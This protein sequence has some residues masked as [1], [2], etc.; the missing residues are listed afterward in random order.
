TCS[1]RRGRSAACTPRP[2]QTFH[3]FSSFDTATLCGLAYRQTVLA[4]ACEVAGISF[5]ADEAHS[6]LYD[7]EKTADIFCSI[8]NKWKELGGL[9]QH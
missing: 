9:M 2:V 4:R 1:S 7:C 6:A 3:P 8:V 5:D